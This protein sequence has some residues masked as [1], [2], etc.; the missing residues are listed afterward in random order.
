MDAILVLIRI[1]IS[2]AFEWHFFSIVNNYEKFKT[3][4]NRLIDDDAVSCY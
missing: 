1:L 2:L 4:R 3:D